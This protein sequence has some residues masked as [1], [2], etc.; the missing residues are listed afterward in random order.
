MHYRESSR[1]PTKPS[2]RNLSRHLVLGLT[3]REPRTTQAIEK[4]LKEYELTAKTLHIGSIGGKPVDLLELSAPPPSDLF[5]RLRAELGVRY[6][7][8]NAAMRRLVLSPDDPR[9]PTQWALDRVAAEAAWERAR[10]ISASSPVVVAIVDSGIQA[11][12]DAASLWVTHPDLAG[13]LAPGVDLSQEQDE[14]GHGTLLAGTVAAVS[15]NARGVASLVWPVADKVR[16]L[17]IKFFDVATPLTSYGGAIAIGQAVARGANIINLSWDVGVPMAVLRDA[18]DDTL[19]NNRLV[20][21]AA[22]NDGTDND[23]WPTWPA[24]YALANMICVMASNHHDDKPGF[25]NYGRTTV[26]LAAPGVDILSTHFY[27]ATPAYREYS[28]SSAACALTTSAAALLMS[29]NPALRPAEI[30]AH[31]QASVDHF[32]WLACASRGRLNANNAVRGPVQLVK[33]HAGDLWVKNTTVD[34]TWTQSYSTPACLNV[35]VLL[36]L[37]NNGP[38]TQ[39]GTS[40]TS[41]GKCTVA[42]PNHATTHAR[43]RVVSDLAPSMY[44]ESGKFQIG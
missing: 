14:D 8:R 27:L 7:E 29:L 1:E 15:N 12:Q 13:T 39:I 36:S 43:V 24:S 20:V 32:P 33:P 23:V 31:L 6:T 26:D 28:G 10:A 41:D 37:Q 34:V 3:D 30:K 25:A 5:V 22:G 2:W 44:A 19:A 38:F 11:V 21:V 4:I 17:P 16:L 42:V 9:Y 35:R 18:L 40:V